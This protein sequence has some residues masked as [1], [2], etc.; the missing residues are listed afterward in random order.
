V[1]AAVFLGLI[2][3]FVAPL[4]AY[5]PVA[6]MA[7]VLLMVAY[8]LI[9]IPAIKSLVRTSRSESA[10]LIVTFIATLLVELQFAI[11]IGVI[12]SLM[13]FLNRT[14]RP[15][16]QD[17]IPAPGQS[18]YHFV[19]RSDEPEC[20]QLKMLVHRRR[21]VLRRRRSCAAGVAR[22]RRG[23]PFAQACVDTRAG[24]QFHRCGRHDSAGAGSAAP[25]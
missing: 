16:I 4:A 9:D 12:V 3:L 5:L 14:S 2:V 10:V 6:A 20:C 24:H 21:A 7:G 25:P 22:D 19:H 23:P 8:S 11:Y 17:A 1:F 18:S 15:A 13:L